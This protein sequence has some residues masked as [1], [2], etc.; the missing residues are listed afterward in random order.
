MKHRNGFVSNSSSSSFVILGVELDDSKVGKKLKTNFKAN[1]EDSW[2]EY[3]FP[4]GIDYLS[5]D[6]NGYAGIR[7]A[8]SDEYCIEESQHTIP[9]L[10]DLAAKIAK[11]L[12]IEI[13]N[14]KLFTGQRSC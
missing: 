12:D 14:V 8:E 10:M 13:S 4:E 11:D 7:I 6:S 9:E 1:D 5:D 3:D 2:D